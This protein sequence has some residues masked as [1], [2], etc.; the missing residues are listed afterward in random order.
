MKNSVL[1]L[2]LAFATF[3][4]T[5]CQDVNRS[6]MRKSYILPDSL[7]N[8]FPQ[9]EP[10]YGDLIFNKI[11]GTPKNDPSSS[12]LCMFSPS[13]MGELY[14]C[15]DSLKRD[16]L[17]R[18]YKKIAIR[19]FTSS[20]DNYFIIGSEYELSKKYDSSF[21][22]EAYVKIHDCSYLI[23]YFQELFDFNEISYDTVTLC[24]LPS[25]Y[26]LFV[27]KSGKCPVLANINS[28]EWNLLPQ[29]VR[30]GYNCGVA[31]NPKSPYILYWAL[32][33]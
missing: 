24:T 8:F 28:Y 17:C 3:L 30:H 26:N 29:N 12:S 2:V 7:Y 13:Y 32:L 14:T 20:D 19:E 6:I 21:F 25:S 23:P 27:L 5:S 16:Q 9:K 15:S 22:K 4:V 31:I 10:L 18:M 11:I 1:L 33:W